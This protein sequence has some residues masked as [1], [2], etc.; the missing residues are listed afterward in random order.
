MDGSKARTAVHDPL[1]MTCHPK[2][3]ADTIVD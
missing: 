1:G 2:E 3:K